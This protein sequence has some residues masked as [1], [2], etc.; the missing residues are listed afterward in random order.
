MSYVMLL[1]YLLV[2]FFVLIP[3]LIGIVYFSW[4]SPPAPITLADHFKVT[5]ARFSR[6]EV[7]Q[8]KMGSS[9]MLGFDTSTKQE[10]ILPEK[11][12]YS[13]TLIVGGTGVGKNTYTVSSMLKDDISRKDSG[14]VIVFDGQRSRL[15]DETIALCKKYGRAYIV[16][17][18][19]RWN[20]L[21]GVGT[22]EERA[23]AFCNVFAQVSGTPD[24]DAGKFFLRQAQA[25]CRRVIPCFEAAYGRPMT[26]REMY[27]LATKEDVR[28]Q[29]LADSSV[30]P[31]ASAFRELHESWKEQNWLANTADLC[32]LIDSMLVGDRKHRYCDITA[33]SLEEHI[34]AGKVIIIRE[35]SYKNTTDHVIGL[36]FMIRIQ[37]YARMREEREDNPFI[38]VYLDEAYQ[39]FTDSYPSFVSQSRKKNIGQILLFQSFGHFE[40]YMTLLTTNFKTIIVMSGLLSEDATF[41]AD[42]IG[43]RLYRHRSTSKQEGRV[44][45]SETSTYSYSYLIE[46]HRIMEL[47][48]DEAILLTQKGRARDVPRHIKLVP[49]LDLSISTRYKDPISGRQAPPLIWDEIRRVLPPTTAGTVESK[50]ETAWTPDWIGDN[51]T[52]DANT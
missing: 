10:F 5:P 28:K 17:P 13:G 3:A 52:D 2:F 23:D 12:R 1:V 8:R 35:G 19:A 44:S 33:P 38:S 15:T 45:G 46:P 16:Y 11:T 21:G 42:T 7:A 47:P 40:P 50:G 29:M 34:D 25:F 9:T 6:R 27:L 30:C 26:L 48:E 43:K 36:L 20:P 51:D 22:A 24:S 32:G 49:P 39:Y 14:A 37:E 18:E 41:V 31:E 4:K